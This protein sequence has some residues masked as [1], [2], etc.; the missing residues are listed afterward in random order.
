MTVQ[1]NHIPKALL[2]SNMKNEITY[3]E[4]IREIRICIK[5]L[6]GELAVYTIHI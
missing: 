5:L 1:K 6:F 2:L 3:T 4:L